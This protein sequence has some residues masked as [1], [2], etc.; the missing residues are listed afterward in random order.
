MCLLCVSLTGCDTVSHFFGISKTSDF[1]RLLKDTSVAS[2][3]EKLGESAIASENLTYPVMN[4]TQKY[5]YRG[6]INEELVETRMRQYNMMNTKT[7]QNILPD[8]HGLKENIKRANLQPYYWRHYLEHNIT[9][10]DLCRA[11]WLIDEMNGLKPL[12]YE[13]SQLPTSMKG[14]RKSQAKGKEVDLVEQS[15]T[16]GE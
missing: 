12:W 15:K 6:K 5:A 3:I 13:C 9:K 11:G 10:V 1:Q 14:K 8:S 4:F 16:I 2:L 7:T